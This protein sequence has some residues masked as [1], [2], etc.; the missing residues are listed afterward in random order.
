M[1][2][3]CATRSTATISKTE[4]IFWNFD[5]LFRICTKFCPFRRKRSALEIKYF[6]SYSL[7]EIWLLE[8]P[9]AAIFKEPWRFNVLTG[10]KHCWP[11]HGSTFIKTFHWSKTHWVEKQLFSEIWN[12]RTVWEHVECRSHVFLSLDK[13]NLGN[14]FHCHY[15]QNGKHFL[16]FWLHFCNLYKIWCIFKT[17]ITFIA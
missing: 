12:V 3:I 11:Y 13:K 7:R 10:I 17:K 1:K 15:L 16:E 2:K 4:N 14:V 5:W 9:K 6:G 8:C